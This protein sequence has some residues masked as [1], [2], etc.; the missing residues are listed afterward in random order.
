MESG[1]TML[2]PLIQGDCDPREV[3]LHPLPVPGPGIEYN[4]QVSLYYF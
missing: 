4:L 1:L 3:T 2:F